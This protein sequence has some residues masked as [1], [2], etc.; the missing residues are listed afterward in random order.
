MNL[1]NEQK[2]KLIETLLQVQVPGLPSVKE[3]SHPYDIGENY[4]IRT[5]THI[6]TGKVVDV[7]DKEIILTQAAWIADTGR[8][9][10][11]IAKGKEPNEVEPY[12]PEALIIVGRGAVIDAAKISTLPLSQK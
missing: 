12:D 11:F 6:D 5:V 1:T 10:D 4:C 9:H 7:T 3:E 2:D 8:F